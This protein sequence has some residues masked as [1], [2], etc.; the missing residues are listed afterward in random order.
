MIK[1]ALSL[2]DKTVDRINQCSKGTVDMKTYTLMLCITNYKG[3]SK[4]NNFHR[5]NVFNVNTE[6]SACQAN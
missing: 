2:Q 3:Q 4:S 1:S 6:L 5:H